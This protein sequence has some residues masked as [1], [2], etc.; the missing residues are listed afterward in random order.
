MNG[1][2]GNRPLNAA[3]NSVFEQYEISFSSGALL[4]REIMKDI[5]LFGFGPREGELVTLYYH[6]ERSE[7]EASKAVSVLFQI[8]QNCCSGF[9]FQ[10]QIPAEQHILRYIFNS[11][12][13]YLIN[14]GVP[15]HTHT[16]AHIHTIP[17][18]PI[19]CDTILTNSCPQRHNNNNSENAVLARRAS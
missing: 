16:H 6:S 2:S 7:L 5:L 9:T 10:L 18:F 8:M 12:F 11:C 13:Y 4:R 14:L 3:Y 19:F 17:H 15:P 1:F